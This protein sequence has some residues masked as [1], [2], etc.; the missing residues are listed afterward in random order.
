MKFKSLL[1]PAA[2]ALMVASLPAHALV[3]QGVTFSM[4]AIDANT[5]RLTIDNALGGGTGNWANIAFIDTFE[6][7]GF[8]DG[9]DVSFADVTSFTGSATGGESIWSANLTNNL[10]NAGCTS[11]GGQKGAC[12]FTPGAPAALSD[13]LV[14]DI[15]FGGVP[16]LR[17]Y[18][19]LH[20]KV[21]FFNTANQT[22]ATGSLLSTEIGLTPAV[23]EPSTYALMLAGLGVVGFVARRRRS[24]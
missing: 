15:D 13:H 16:D 6:I 11:N 19:E 8:G 24:N 23:P 7:K 18:S 12:I 20:L 17:G 22:R 3:S 5:L 14:W 1:A 2:A 21:N 9:Y 10:A 4:E